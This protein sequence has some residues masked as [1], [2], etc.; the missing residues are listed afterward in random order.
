M[1]YEIETTVPKHIVQAIISELETAK[2]KFPLWPDDPIHAAAIVAEESGELVRATVRHV[3]EEGPEDEIQTEAIQTA[4]MCI[5]LLEAFDSN[6][7]LP[8]R[9]WANQYVRV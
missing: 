6:H 9:R 8:Q 3:Y 2:L 5:R 4:A 1:T 7:Y